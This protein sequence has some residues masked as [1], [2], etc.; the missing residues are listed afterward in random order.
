MVVILWINR[1]EQNIVFKIV[2][3]YTKSSG[4]SAATNFC[5]KQHLFYKH[6]IKRE[7]PVRLKIF[8]F[9]AMNKHIF[10]CFYTYI[11]IFAR[12]RVAVEILYTIDMI[13]QISI[14]WLYMYKLMGIRH[15]SHSSYTC[16]WSICMN[17]NPE[18]KGFM[19]TLAPR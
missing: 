13:M 19:T 11:T 14:T 16:S 6:C 8:F 10:R 5:R 3:G 17:Q 2:K 15:T 18:N 9:R 4:S 1:I 12:P 7:G